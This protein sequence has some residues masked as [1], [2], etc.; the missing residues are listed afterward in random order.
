MPV[1]IKHGLKLAEE[2]DTLIPVKKGDLLEIS[3]G[4]LSSNR[5]YTWHKK[6]TTNHS[7]TWETNVTQNYTAI[8][9]QTDLLWELRLTPECLD[10]YFIISSANYGDYMM[11]LPLKASP[12][13]YNVLSKDSTTIRARK[14]DFAMIDKL[15]LANSSA[16]YLRFADKASLT[17]CANVFTRVTRLDCHEGYIECVPM[18]LESDQ[19]RSCL[20]DFWSSYAYQALMALGYRIK[21]RMTEQTSQK[22]DIDS[23]SS[24]TEQYPNHLCYLKLMA[25]Y[26]QA[27]QNRFFD[28]NQEYDRV[29]PMSPSTVLDQWIYVPRIYL[30]PY[31]IYPQPIKPTRGN[32]ILRQ[33]E[34]FGPYEHFCRVMIRDVDLGTA[35]AAFIKTNEEWIKNL[36]IAEDP[37]YVGNRHFWFLLCS[38]S[39]L[40]DRSFWFHAP[41]LGRTAV[42][43]RRWMGDF[44]RETCI[45]TCIARMALTL[46]GTTPS[47]TL[48]HDQME[49]ID[50]KKDDQERAF[51]DGA[52]KIS[53]KALK[54]ALMIYRSD[55][56]DDDY[57]SCV[58]QVRLNGLKGIFVKA[59]DLEDKD[60]LIQYRPSQCKFDVNHNELEIVKH[61]RSAKAVLNKQIIM[62]LENM[63]VK[64]QHFI[65]LQNQ[66]R[67][68]IS[69]SLLENKAAERTLKHHAQFYDWE[70]MRSVGIQLIKEPFA[71]SLIL[72]HVRERLRGL[73]ETFNISIPQSDGRVLVGV[74]DETNSLQY[75]QVFIQ[76]RGPNGENQIV[77]SCKVLITKN[78][79]HFPG[80]ILKLDA[81]D[82]PAL[83]HLDEC[84][85][86]PTQGPRPH[87]N[88]TSGSD[89]DGDEFWVCWNKDLVGNATQ[90][91]SPALF[92]AP[93][94]DKHDGPITMNEIADFIFKYLSS[95]SLGLL[96][97]RHIA[98]CA[99]YGPSDAKSCQLAQ[100]I[101][102]AVDFPK[103]GVAPK[104]PTDIKIDKYPDFMEVK[105]KPSFESPSSLGVMY[106]QIK[107]VWQIHSSWIKKMETEQIHVD[108]R[109]LIPGYQQYV[110]QADQDYQY[111]SSKINTII[112]IYNLA[113]EYELITAYHSCTEVELKNNDSAETSFLEFRCL[114][115]EMRQRFAADQLS[116][117][118]QKMKAS[119]WY[120]VAYQAGTI[121]SFAWIMTELMCDIIQDQNIVQED[122]QALKR[123]GE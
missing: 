111:Y 60:V 89:T 59:P 19:F 95:D 11:I 61:F 12:K 41:Y 5:T 99:I 53:P 102:D 116:C 68:N 69:M 81:V 80:D 101:S 65:R 44:S 55:L 96:S 39:Q 117:E 92:N 6:I 42:H 122:D 108:P 71:H 115:R 109:F 51:T 94:K 37:I 86:F 40:K 119:A 66:V 67:L 87:P 70:R 43:I 93:E 79:A 52:G 88:E 8:L 114:L 98:C 90:L 83:H 58:I 31:C 76:L 77:H 23:K 121:L 1:W 112:L 10:T 100:T 4:Y 21:H 46:T 26:F 35:R 25:I 38:N 113:D 16:I 15:C 49:C 56:V 91:H 34:Q 17:V 120:Y 63:G 14:L 22:M 54:Q 97:R 106:R 7:L 84:I 36:I 72:L 24:Q 82:C 73:K 9:Y 107:E 30:T 28:I 123:I 18:S 47:I 75:G 57:R 48:T 110:D 118:E 33:K 74:V 78:P 62:L 3:F 85:V 50:D 2:S 27:Q 32:R 13:C 45:G 103:T 104:V 29:K 20:L 105:N 64:E